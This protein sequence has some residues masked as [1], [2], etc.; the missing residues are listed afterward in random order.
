MANETE[1]PEKQNST[2][3]Y[4]APW[5]SIE[6]CLDIVK[7]VYEAKGDAV[8]T[9]EEVYAITGSPRGTMSPK[10][11]ACTMYGFLLSNPRKG[12]QVTELFT[13]IMNPEFEE[14]KRKKLL[15][16]FNTPP[17]YKKLIERYNSKSLP[18]RQGLLNLLISSEFG[19]N[20]NSTAPKTTAAFFENCEYLNLVEGGRLRYFIP[21]G[22]QKTKIKHAGED[23]APPPPPPPTNMFELPIDLGDD[24]IAY[25][26][27]P[28]NITPHEISILKIMLD[29]SLAS[30]AA[31]QKKEG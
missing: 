11:S 22:E 12:Y 28:K 8:V 23:G 2:S 25:L 10:L 14:D 7:Q 15:E 13:S 30:L 17:L 1:T 29:A 3:D 5:A 19:L 24:K 31:R 9:A 18:N 20:K 21:A 6:A 4:A 27:Y 16:A 26:K